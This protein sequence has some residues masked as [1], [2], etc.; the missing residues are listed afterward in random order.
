MESSPGGKRMKS[1]TAG[2]WLTDYPPTSATAGTPPPRKE[3]LRRKRFL[4]RRSGSQM[5]IGLLTTD[6]VSFTPMSRRH[7]GVLKDTGGNPAFWEFVRQLRQTTRDCQTVLD[8]GCGD[9]SPARFLTNP[10][11]V[12]IDGY[13]PSVKTA[14][15]RGTHDEV[16][17][18][19]V[20]EA[21]RLFAG[22]RFD[23]CIA[24]DVIEHLP[25]DDGWRMLE[26]MERLANKVVVIFTPN[27]F[28][29]QQSKNGDLQEHLSGWLPEEMRARNY[30]VRGMQGPKGLRG[31][32]AALL[33]RPKFFWGIVSIFGH[34][35]YTRR[36]PEKAFS[37][38][39]W[40]RLAGR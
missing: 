22:R 17:L 6:L 8:L 26:A 11:L 2:H 40:K 31:E 38:Y 27:G 21:D 34:F 29:P 18:G 32:Y 35:L 4:G 10:T 20:R 19:D 15:E 12:G 3:R 39:C 24:L 9:S 25:K 7:F 16:V 23:A 5:G 14:R 36:C 13:E 30:T 33:N 37:I 28:V 1:K